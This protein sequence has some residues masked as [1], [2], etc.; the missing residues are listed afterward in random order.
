MPGEPGRRYATSA[1]LALA[2]LLWSGNF[3][4]GRAL[5]DEITPVSLNFLR[6]TIG[7][8][9]LFAI[10][11]RGA[12][13]ARGVVRREWKLV[14][15]VGL[16]GIAAFHT[17][18]YLA[19]LDT[20]AINAL[21]LLAAAPIAIMVAAWVA[22]GERFTGAQKLGAIVSAAGAVTL[23]AH[24]DP[25]ALLA[26]HGNVG[27]LWMVAAVIIWAAYSV[28]LK[29]R[30]ADLPPQVLLTASAGAGLAWMLPVYLLELLR[31][32]AGFTLT[33]ATVFG[34]AYVAVAAS[35]LAFM[36]WS[37][38]VAQVGPSKA[39]QYIHLMPF[40]GAALS[41][42]FLG[43]SVA[44]HHI[45]G[46]ALVFAGIALSQYVGARATRGGSPRT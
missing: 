36:L 42:V 37:Y 16:T 11:F 9:L 40:F 19:L 4:I 8:A 32:D 5:R 18:V 3:I 26:L 34:I 22:A 14:A 33:P 44:W 29:R 24:G 7:F 38:G 46:G 2:A 28:A 27:D 12:V 41:I 25:A 6:W 15:F 31:G 45:A 10:G 39:G 30:P 17:C 13:A 21:L 43:E 1:A 35:V 20:T 23:V